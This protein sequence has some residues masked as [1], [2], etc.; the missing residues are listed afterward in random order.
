MGRPFAPMRTHRHRT[1]ALKASKDPTARARAFRD[2]VTL[3]ATHEIA[4]MLVDPAV[5][6]CVQR[7]GFGVYS[8]EVADPVE[9]D[10]FDIKGF[11]MTD[12]VYPSWYEQFHKTRRPSITVRSVAVRFTS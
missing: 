3:T 8:L 5:T 11:K 1:R 2:E 12:F 4:E 10:G 9:E 6:Y 7:V